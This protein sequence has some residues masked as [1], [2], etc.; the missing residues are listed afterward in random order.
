MYCFL[1]AYVFSDPDVW[2]TLLQFFLLALRIQQR[3]NLNELEILTTNL[4][5]VIMHSE[6]TQCFELPH[7]LNENDGVK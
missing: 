1:S 4:L 5:E 3:D 6:S 2:V 7:F